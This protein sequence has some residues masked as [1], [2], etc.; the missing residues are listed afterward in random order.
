VCVCDCGGRGADRGGGG[1]RLG[2]AGWWLGGVCV[3]LWGGG[4]VYV[5]QVTSK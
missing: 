3:V 1:R 4:Y 2:V 5:A